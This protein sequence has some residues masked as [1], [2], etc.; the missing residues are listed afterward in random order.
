MYQNHSQ[1][2]KLFIMQ[3]FSGK[4]ILSLC[5]NL[6][7]PLLAHRLQILGASITKVEP[8]S[9][10]PLKI[11]NQNFYNFLNQKQNI[12]NLNLK[13]PSDYIQFKNLLKNTDLFITSNRPKALEKLNIIWESLHQEF[14]Q[15]CMLMIVGENSPHENESGHDLTYQAKKGLLTPPQIPLVPWADLCGAQEALI[16]SFILFALKEQTHFGHLKRVSLSESLNSFC[17]PK[18]FGLSGNQNSYLGGLLPQYNIYETKMGWVAVACLEPHF[19]KIFQLE[20]GLEIEDIKNKFLQKSAQ[21][22]EAWAKEKDLP[23]VKII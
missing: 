23:I 5:C 21:E 8:P 7:G 12:I 9:G 17:L 10:D 22:W 20:M 18:D 2:F 16:Q 6:P 4:N 1:C 19:L 14:P 11:Y 13:N 3:V 15:L